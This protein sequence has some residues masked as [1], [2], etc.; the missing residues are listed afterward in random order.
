MP[1][2]D[3][4]IDVYQWTRPDRPSVQNAPLPSSSALTC[5][6]S[7]KL[8]GASGGALSHARS[9][10]REGRRRNMAEHGGS[11]CCGPGY[12]SPV[13]AMKAPRGKLLYTLAL[14]FGAGAA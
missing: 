7:A 12:A 4:I 13:E 14:Y 10:Q 2:Q 5:R 9:R 6:E 11:H 1:G 3:Q 8:V